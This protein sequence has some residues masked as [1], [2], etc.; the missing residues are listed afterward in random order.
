METHILFKIISQKVIECDIPDHQM[1]RYPVHEHYFVEATE[2]MIIYKVKLTNKTAQNLEAY[3]K[4][5]TEFLKKKYNA[6]SV[7][8]GQLQ[9]QLTAKK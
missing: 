3:V 5:L 6:Y 1:H 8:A 4:F 9:N 7:E 2:K